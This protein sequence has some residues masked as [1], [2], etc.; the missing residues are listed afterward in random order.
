M[1]QRT[2]FKRLSSYIY[3]EHPLFVIPNYQEALSGQLNQRQRFLF[4]TST[5]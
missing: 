3:D 5:T 2:Q 1:E 4:G